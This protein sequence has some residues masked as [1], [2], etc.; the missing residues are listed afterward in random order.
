[1][2]LCSRAGADL[3]LFAAAAFR[4]ARPTPSSHRPISSHPCV[5]LDLRLADLREQ[6]FWQKLTRRS[7]NSDISSTRPTPRL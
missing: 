1:M 4:G 6:A 2:R 3:V 5:T 7:Q